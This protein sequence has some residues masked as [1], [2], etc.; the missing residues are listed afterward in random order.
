M[1][2]YILRFR[3]ICTV[4]LAGRT[5]LKGEI[6]QELGISHAT[7]TALMDPKDEQPHLHASTLGKIQDFVRKYNYYENMDPKDTKA[8]KAAT[9]KMKEEA[10]KIIKPDPALLAPGQEIPPRPLTPEFADAKNRLKPELP[11]LDGEY[12][13]PTDFFVHLRR[14]I[15][16]APKGT[17]ITITLTK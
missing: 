7:F 13:V 4:L 16:A 15:E 12:D 6:R 11:N 10:K 17:T 8:V 3:K 9:G 5:K 2:D 14:A 1:N